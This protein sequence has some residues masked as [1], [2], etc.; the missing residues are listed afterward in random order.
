[1]LC[2]YITPF[3]TLLAPS[4]SLTT[5]V[6]CVAEVFSS[7]STWRSNRSVIMGSSLFLIGHQYCSGKWNTDC[8][9]IMWLM[10]FIVDCHCC[11]AT[12][13]AG[14]IM[15]C[16]CYIIV[17]RC[18]YSTWHTNRKKTLMFLVCHSWDVIHKILH[19]HGL[20]FFWFITT[21]FNVKTGVA[22]HVRCLFLGVDRWVLASWLWAA[23]NWFV[24]DLS[25]RFSLIW[26]RTVGFH[27][28]V[29]RALCSSRHIG[30][31]FSP[32]VT[33]HRDFRIP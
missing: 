31:E 8:V 28:K 10:L 6:Q 4:Y 5:C 14:Y 32:F 9:K 20:I 26:R 21:F 3:L 25:V 22:T 27:Y 30:K 33:R 24:K 19:G 13:H 12:W 1:M 29:S 23:L 2:I 18:W 16:G 15:S 17:R 7:C 11:Y